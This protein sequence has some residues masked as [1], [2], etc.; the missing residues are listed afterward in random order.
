MI[1]IDD[2]GFRALAEK[3]SRDR[4]FACAN[5]KQRCV[6]RR[7]AVRMRARGI[8]TFDEYSAL[9]DRDPEEFDR[10]ID[11]LT[12]NVTKFFR[13]AE[14]WTAIGRIV[15]PAVWAARRARVR[16]WSAGCASGEEAYSLA[17]LF[18]R[19]AERI[20]DMAGLG[21]VEVL[22][23]DIDA[24]SLEAAERAVFEP[25]AF[26]DTPADLRARYFTPVPPYSPL[27]IIRAITRFERHDLLRDEIPL[28]RYDLIVCRNV[29]IYFDRETQERLIDAFHA[30]LTPGGVL[31]LGKVET[32]LGTARTRFTALD[33]RERVFQKT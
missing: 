22:G 33:S 24:G 28:Q 10:L 13:N 4:G 8:P 29:L 31:V 3:I 25:D 16:V 9:L 2:A 19:H 1:D 18:H 14:V 17:I 20:G 32:L 26:T 5:Y 6:L 30:A 23:T 12:I 27:A 11:T 21:T 15:V 7:I